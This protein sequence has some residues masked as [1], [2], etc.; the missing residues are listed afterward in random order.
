MGIIGSVTGFSKNLSRLKKNFFRSFRHVGHPLP[1]LAVFA[2]VVAIPVMLVFSADQAESSVDSRVSEPSAEG[3]A[4]ELCR[5]KKDVA[6]FSA[7][8]DG[9]KPDQEIVCQP[10]K[11]TARAESAPAA[12]LHPGSGGRP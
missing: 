9:R 1:G 3:A 5:W 4:D 10:A 2:G 11:K 8:R 6:F 7:L 12:A